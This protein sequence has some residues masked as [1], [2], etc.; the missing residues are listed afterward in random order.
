MRKGGSNLINRYERIKS[1]G[2]EMSSD[3]DRGPVDYSKIKIG[4]KT[5]EDATV[6]LNG[7]FKRANKG[8]GNKDNIL[9]YI[10][11]YNTK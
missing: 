4:L 2:F 7:D 6:N 5:L 9:Q 10:N 11:D 1:K 8:L 3:L